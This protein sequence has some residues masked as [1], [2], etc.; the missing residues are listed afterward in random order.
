MGLQKGQSYINFRLSYEYEEGQTP[1]ENIRYES[2]FAKVDGENGYYE[3]QY[4]EATSYQS[5]F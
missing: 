3:E 1:N 4:Y 5:T 2:E